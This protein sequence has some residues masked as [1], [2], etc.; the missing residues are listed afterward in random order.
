VITPLLGK[1]FYY[2]PTHVRPYYPQSL[3]MLTGGLDTPAAFRA[4]TTLALEDVYF[5]KDSWRLRE[6]RTFYPVPPFPGLGFRRAFVSGV[7]H[8]LAWLHY[9]SGGRLG[10][11]A[12][13]LGS[14]RRKPAES[15]QS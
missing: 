5:F 15:R 13:W 7:N 4:R 9:L 11:K 2:D 6:A 10:V 12:S 3:R 14:Y 1:R 8:C